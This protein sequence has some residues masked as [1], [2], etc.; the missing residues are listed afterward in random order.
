MPDLSAELGWGGGPSSP[1]AAAAAGRAA[2][3]GPPRVIELAAVAPRGTPAGGA[4]HTGW[5]SCEFQLAFPLGADGDKATHARAAGPGMHAAAEEEASAAAPEAAAAD[6]EAGGSGGKAWEARRPKFVVLPPAFAGQCACELR[7]LPRCPEDRAAAVDGAEDH[8]LL[9]WR[10]ASEVRPRRVGA[11]AEPVE[12]ATCQDDTCQYDACQHDAC[13]GGAASSTGPT[14]SV[15]AKNFSG[16]FRDDLRNSWHL[17]CH[18]LF[19]ES[20]KETRAE[21]I[22]QAPHLSPKP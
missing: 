13:N 21:R 7:V 6:A 9:H 3:S 5:Q 20:L 12:Y 11:A 2:G 1:A 18:G 14:V 8:F 17:F 15:E 19:H 10:Q 22:W 16:D 4:G